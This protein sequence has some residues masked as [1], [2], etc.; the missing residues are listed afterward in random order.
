MEKDGSVF[1]S[2]IGMVAQLAACDCV[3]MQLPASSDKKLILAAHAVGALGKSQIASVFFTEMTRS[4]ASQVAQAGGFREDFSVVAAPRSAE[5]WKNLPEVP[6]SPTAPPLIV[7]DLPVA[8]AAEAVRQLKAAG[9]LIL[10]AGADAQEVDAIRAASIPC[11]FALSSCEEAQT[12]ADVVLLSDFTGCLGNVKQHCS[13]AASS[14]AMYVAKS[15][16]PQ[17]CGGI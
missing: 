7:C 16:A 17:I 6:L 14:P 13:L 4:Q 2:E 15:I 8:G 1:L 3:A 5:E 10:Y 9:H 12:T 11:A